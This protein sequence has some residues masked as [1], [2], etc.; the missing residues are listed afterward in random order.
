MAARKSFRSDIAWATPDAV[1]V[2]GHDLCRDLLGKVSLGDM[3]FLQL[4]D[5]F[6]NPKEA[7]VFNALSITLMEHGMTPSALAARLTLAGAPDAI[8]AAVAA[9][10]CGLG[11]VFVGSTEAAAKML[12]EAFAAP[13]QREDLKTIAA[14]IAKAEHAAGRRLPGI[15]HHFHKPVDP[16][17]VRLFEIAEAN[18][19]GGHYVG[20][21]KEV[22]AASER[23]TGKALP[24]N[25]T[26]AVAA[27][28]SELG[29]HW[30]TVPGLGIIARTVG[31]VAHIREERLNPLAREIKTRV[32]E[33]ATAHLRVQ[34]GR[35]H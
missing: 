15:G 25:A 1:Y 17:A 7:T 13:G 4:M 2:K 33:E 30:S 6:P 9:G 22:A 31:L 12:Q 14:E 24:V 35:K 20:L 28:A 29:M 5:R 16:R 8:Q 23:L 26:G 3:T 11:S 21:M 32:E 34:L 19:F 27:V 10:L 18:G